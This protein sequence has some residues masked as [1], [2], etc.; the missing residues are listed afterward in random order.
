MAVKA[1]PGRNRL[2]RINTK[3]FKIAGAAL[4]AVAVIAAISYFISQGEISAK[5]QDAVKA[6]ASKGYINVGLRGD[7][8]SLCLYDEAAGTYSGLEKDIADEII[9][10]LFP[11]GIIVNYINVNS[12]TKDALLQTGDVDIS[13]G[14]SVNRAVEGIYYTSPYFTDPSAFLVREGEMTAIKEFS[15]STV[16]IVQGSRAATKPKGSKKTNLE[17]YFESIDISANVRVYASYPEAIEA[18]RAGYVKGVC[19]NELFLMLFGKSGML[20]LGEKCIP[21]DYC[22]QTWKNLGAFG[23]AVNDVIKDMIKD[24]TMAGLLGKW[25]LKSYEAPAE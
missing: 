15:G 23:D 18:L 19:A 11:D 21:S 7:L 25:Q 2:F 17:I 22:V 16:A 3:Y 4:F 10:K 20:L 5:K 24:G 14:A 13:L 12:E 9:K 1:R 6:V 8:G